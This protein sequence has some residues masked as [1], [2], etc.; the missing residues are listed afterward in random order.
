MDSVNRLAEKLEPLIRDL[1]DD[2]EFLSN[3][4]EE[5]ENVSRLLAYTKDN[6]DMV[7]VYADQELIVSNLSK[8]N[9][10]KDEYKASCYLLKSENENIKSLPQYKKAHDLISDIIE[11]FKL[12][13]AELMVGIKNLEES[14]AKKEIEKKY[15]NI[16][17]E[18]NPFN[19][20]VDEFRELLDNHS[21]PNNDKIEIL[22]YTINSNGKKYGI[23]NK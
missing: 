15:Y 16:L 13:K 18:E 3:Q 23:G 6:I 10:D 12:Y 4:K 20:D 14:C 5:L 21:V 11:Y 17:K 2:K 9:T 7:G 1:D 19:K 8:I 22:L